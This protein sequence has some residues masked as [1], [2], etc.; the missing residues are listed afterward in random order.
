[1]LEETVDW[2]AAHPARIKYRYRPRF[3]PAGYATLPPGVVW[4]YVEAPPCDYLPSLVGVPVSRHR[5]GVIATD[6]ELTSDEIKT[7]ELEPMK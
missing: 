3:R 2:R 1:M 5:Y 4:H 6:R 7:F